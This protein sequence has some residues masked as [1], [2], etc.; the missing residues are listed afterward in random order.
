MKIYFWLNCL[1]CLLIAPMIYLTFDI[2]NLDIHMADHYT[3]MNLFETK[4]GESNFINKLLSSIYYPFY[5]VFGNIGIFIINYF[6]YMLFFY[7]SKFLIN[8]TLVFRRFLI[9]FSPYSMIMLFNIHREIFLIIAVDILL[10]S[11]IYKHILYKLFSLFFSTLLIF[12]P[13]F[14]L[15]LLYHIFLRK[16]IFK[17]FLSYL[18]IISLLYIGALSSDIYYD[19]NISRLSMADDNSFFLQAIENNLILFLIVGY[20]LI[21]GTF[22]G[23]L[24]PV[25]NLSFTSGFLSLTMFIT[26][27]MIIYEL[28]NI[29]IKRQFLNDFFMLN[30]FVSMSFFIAFSSWIWGFRYTLPILILIYITS[31]K[32]MKKSTNRRNR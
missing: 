20:N 9:A 17:K 10:L 11:I 24:S 7:L 3:Y 31:G 19:E 4:F 22:G 28:F 30:F 32:I 14:G 12:R 8:D 29:F 18:L 25:V 1:I 16:I 2:L 13:I 6:L 26:S 23:F 5:D 27:L 21:M 15:A